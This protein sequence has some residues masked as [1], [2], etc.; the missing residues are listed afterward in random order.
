MQDPAHVGYFLTRLS[1]F[2]FTEYKVPAARD[3][4]D[5]PKR[6]LPSVRTLKT[7]VVRL[8]GVE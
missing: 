4:D 1:F 7:I 6:L 2:F 8:D 5:T 3:D